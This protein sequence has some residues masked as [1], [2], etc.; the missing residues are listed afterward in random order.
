MSCLDPCIGFWLTPLPWSPCRRAADREAA[1]Q[2]AATRQ[3]EGL[4][5]Q[6]RA[7]RPGLSILGVMHTCGV[8][9]SMA[10]LE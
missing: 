1:I 9:G 3:V 8:N 10:T 6:V 4:T 5:M 2:K 7:A